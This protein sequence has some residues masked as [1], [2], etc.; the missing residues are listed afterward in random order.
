MNWTFNPLFDNLG[1]PKVS[2]KSHS[3]FLSPYIITKGNLSLRPAHVPLNRAYNL[4][5]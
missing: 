1:N 3:A 5:D 4:M 2:D